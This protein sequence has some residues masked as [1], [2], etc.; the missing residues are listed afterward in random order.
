MT[1]HKS[2]LC[3]S[4]AVFACLALAACAVG[5]DFKKPAPPAANSLTAA[6]LPA[7]AATPGVVGGEAQTFVR[8]PISRPTGGPSSIP[9]P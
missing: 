4:T 3:R 9:S 2:I 1:N 6:P 5:P 8:A 7:T